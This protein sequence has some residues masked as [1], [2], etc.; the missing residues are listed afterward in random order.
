MTRLLI[1]PAGASA[2]GGGFPG[3]PLATQEG[4]VRP[5]GGRAA[6]GAVMGPPPTA[7]YWT[8]EILFLLVIACYV[9]VILAV[10]AR[11]S[12]VAPA[13]LPRRSPGVHPQGV[14]LGSGVN[15]YWLVHPVRLIRARRSR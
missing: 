12:Q 15:W 5:T 13:T 6:G 3:W 9:A 8:G 1:R 11:R 2:P 7:H 14:R 10:T 4:L